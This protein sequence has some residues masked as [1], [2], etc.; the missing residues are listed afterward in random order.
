MYLTLVALVRGRDVLGQ[1]RRRLDL[2]RLPLV[3]AHRVLPERRAR[4]PHGR[5]LDVEQVRHVAAD[6][7]NHECDH[8]AL[9]LAA[10]RG[11]QRVGEPGPDVGRHVERLVED[12]VF[13]EERRLQR[14]GLGGHHRRRGSTGRVRDRLRERR[15]LNDHHL[16]L[17]LE[18]DLDFFDVLNVFAVVYLRGGRRGGH[19]EGAGAPLSSIVA[20]PD[21]VSSVTEGW[22]KWSAGSW[23]T[24]RTAETAAGS[25][26]AGPAARRDGCSIGPP[27]PEK[28]R[29][30]G[31]RP[32]S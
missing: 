28:S 32:R 26:A 2:R 8:R 27:S 12:Q 3:D 29:T 30:E 24:A 9:E 18:L 7:R 10:Q 4:A 16:L 17:E 15:R 23:A 1:P 5:R 13:L 11:S 21:C 6:A 19:S 22:Q 25:A 20:M 31:T 14:Q